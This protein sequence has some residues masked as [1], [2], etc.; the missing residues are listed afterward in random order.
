MR[1]AGSGEIDRTE[2]SAY[3]TIVVIYDESRKMLSSDSED[4]D[5]HGI[6]ITTPTH[7]DV[8]APVV[9]PKRKRRRKRKHLYCVKDKIKIVQ[10]AYGKERNVNATAKAY[11][12]A[13]NLIRAWKKDLPKLMAKAQVNPRA[14]TSHKGR[15]VDDPDLESELLTW[16]LHQR[17]ED[18]AV[19]PSDIVN[20]AITLKP[21]FKNGEREKLRRW[22]YLF[23][24]RHGL[25][26]RRVTRI[27]QKLSGHLKEVQEDMA[28]SV[29]LRLA[30]GGSLH[31]MDLK[32]FINMDQT[33]VWFEMKSGTTVD[34]VGKNTI[35]IRDSGSNSKRC[36]VVL[37]V[38][39]DGTKLPP[40]VVFKGL[41]DLFLS[42]V[43]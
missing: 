9:C 28:E 21:D 20:Q 36:T 27:G 19:R 15:K 35:S 7:A 25:S 6:D 32:H 29:R 40:F 18:M 13:G 38:A 24:A 33:A 31:G 42:I 12:I 17:S 10:I 39:A 34:L 23:L 37:A 26:I 16:V 41:F 3:G 11:A 22:S 4:E 1:F 30:E 8:V 2:T 14:F 43:L 5:D